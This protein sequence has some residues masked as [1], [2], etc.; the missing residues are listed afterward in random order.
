MLALQ[1][2]DSRDQAPAFCHRY[3]TVAD[4]HFQ[5]RELLLEARSGA[6][7]RAIGVADPDHARAVPQLDRAADVTRRIQDRRRKL[8]R[9]A[10]A[11]R[12]E[13]MS[14]LDVPVAQ[15]E[16]SLGGHASVRVLLSMR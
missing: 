3:Q 4:R 6:V 16:Q 7:D 2:C 9:R 8:E 11:R 15:E 10:V 14:G 13:R 5:P 12:F 1:L